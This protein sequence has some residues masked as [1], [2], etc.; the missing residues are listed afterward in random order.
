MR[1]EVKCLTKRISL[2]SWRGG[3]LTLTEVKANKLESAVKSQKKKKLIKLLQASLNRK[4]G[5]S[6]R[7]REMKDLQEYSRRW[8]LRVFKVPEKETE[9]AA[10]CTAKVCVVF[11]DRVGILIMPVGNRGDT[12]D[13]TTQQHQSKAHSCALL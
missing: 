12:Q 6:S 9:T 4:P 5:E 13:R 10:N 1:A 8:N 2:G 7:M 11:S 3:C